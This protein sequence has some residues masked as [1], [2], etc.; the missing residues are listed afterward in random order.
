MMRYLR[1]GILHA[2]LAASVATLAV[3]AAR[4][5][6]SHPLTMAIS[7][8]GEVF[9]SQSASAAKRIHGFGIT[10]DAL[11]ITWAGVA[12]RQEPG[13]WDPRDSNDPNYH[14]AV[15]DD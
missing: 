6:T 14:W 9:G 8:A 2:A 13:S 10:R 1:Y 15:D 4:A 5:A 11:T 7:G 12:P 3:Q